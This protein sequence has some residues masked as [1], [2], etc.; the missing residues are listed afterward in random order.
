M[1]ILPENILRLMRESD[2]AKLGLA[3]Q[4]KS[5]SQE[6]YLAGQEEKLQHDIRS[7]LNLHGIEFI[8]PSMR[9]KSALPVGWPDFSFAYR[10][11]PI[12]LE[13]K[14]DAGR[15]TGEQL[16]MHAKLRANGWWILVARSLADVQ[17]LFREIDRSL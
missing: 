14:T 13:A 15:C 4:T 16:E 2:R 12:G 8:N 3:G 6:R 17:E 9:R 1:S 5:E 11:A 10:G 7:Y